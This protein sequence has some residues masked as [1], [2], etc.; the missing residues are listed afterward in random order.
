MSD[1][2]ADGRVTVEVM[3]R[4][5]SRVTTYLCG[6]CGYESTDM[7]GSHQTHY[8]AHQTGEDR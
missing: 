8:L 7:W 3:E 5:N 1:A 2:T 6:V 4:V